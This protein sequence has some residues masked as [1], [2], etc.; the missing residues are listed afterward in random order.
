MKENK[1]MSNIELLRI[2]AMFFIVCPHIFIY[3]DLGRENTVFC[4]INT[5]L[6]PCVNIFMLIS[7]YFLVDSKF[8]VKKIIKL[9]LQ[10][11]FYYLFCTVLFR[12]VFNVDVILKEDI[13]SILFPILYP[14]E[15]FSI[16]YIILYILSPF[17]NK[18]L[19][20]LNKKEHIVLIV[21]LII[22]AYLQR[23]PGFASYLNFNYGYSILWFITIYVVA[24]FIKFYYKK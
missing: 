5:L 9:Y 19:H 13:T 6:S 18:M 1:R 4:I 17:L 21:T 14:Q 10:I 3:S 2:I 20:N 8:K 22:F 16:N 23:F 11:V 24:A 7:G 12:Y 15:W